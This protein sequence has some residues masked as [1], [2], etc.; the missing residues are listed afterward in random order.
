MPLLIVLSQGPRTPWASE[1]TACPTRRERPCPATPGEA[2]ARRIPGSR[3]GG[4]ICRQSARA[5]TV[6]CLTGM[7]RRRPGRPRIVMTM[8]RME[9]LAGSDLVMWFGAGAAARLSEWG[10]ARGSPGERM[11]LSPDPIGTSASW[12]PAQSSSGSY[13]GGNPTIF[14]IDARGIIRRKNSIRKW[15]D[16]SVDRPAQGTRGPIPVGPVVPAGLHPASARSPRRAFDR[17]TA[18]PAADPWASDRSF[19]GFPRRQSPGSIHALI[20]PLARSRR[21]HAY[22]PGERRATLTAPYP[23]PRSD[24]GTPGKSDH[25]Q[26]KQGLAEVRRRGIPRARRESGLRY[27]SCFRRDFVGYPSP[28]WPLIQGRRP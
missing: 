1:F 11:R 13:V 18:G 19:Q 10:T 25:L 28:P 17:R 2:G 8:K 5:N 20:R 26:G 27:S 6:S 3:Y 21:G 22:K 23:G 24:S 9:S 12:G 15:L 4:A 16:K 7:T 14:V